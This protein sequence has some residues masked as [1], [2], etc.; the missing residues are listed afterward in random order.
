MN[1]T[2]AALSA[3]TI[4]LTQRNAGPSLNWLRSVGID[5]PDFGE[6]YFHPG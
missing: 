3:E 5:A 4:H 1:V 2:E 6:G